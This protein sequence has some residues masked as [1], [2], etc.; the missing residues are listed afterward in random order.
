[1]AGAEWL[2]EM[3]LVLLLGATLFHALRLE[4]ALGVLKR[5]RAVLEELVEGFNDSTRQAETG[6]ERLRAAAD[7][8]GRQMARQIET[9]QRLRDDLTFLSDRSEKMA[10]RLE[11]AVRAARMIPE[12]ALMQGAVLASAAS[13]TPP[14]PPSF[15]PPSPMPPLPSHGYE[16]EHA[17]PLSFAP[18]PRPR[19]LSRA[20]PP[21]LSLL[22][23]P[24]REREPEAELE[25]T[26][27]L[28]SQAERDLLRALRN[29][30]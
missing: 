26:P 1:M 6:V 14:A 18:S 22:S 11:G 16:T 8:A 5:D 2:L 7:G 25:A 17:P 29:G 20:A 4:R 19:P 23:E 24:E 21:K 9:A 3:V 27:R 28:R 30:R 15:M 10:E 12:S 13:Q